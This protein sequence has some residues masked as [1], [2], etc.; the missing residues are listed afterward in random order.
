MLHFSD[1]LD[2]WG[3]NVCRL[4]YYREVTCQQ[5]SVWQ[6][7]AK[8][9]VL[10]DGLKKRW[11]DLDLDPL[12]ECYLGLPL[13]LRATVIP[14][15]AARPVL[16]MIK[17]KMIKMKMVQWLLAMVQGVLVMI[18]V[19]R[20]HLHPAQHHVM[21]SSKKQGG[22]WCLV[23]VKQVGWDNAYIT[24]KKNNATKSSGTEDT[25]LES[26]HR[27][28]CFTEAVSDWM[29][30]ENG[31]TCRKLGTLSKML[32]FFLAFFCYSAMMR[33]LRV[34]GWIEY[35]F[36]AYVRLPLVSKI[37]VYCGFCKP[38]NYWGSG[39]CG[40]WW[41]LKELTANRVQAIC[42]SEFGHGGL[43]FLLAN[44][45]SRQ[46]FGLQGLNVCM[47]LHCVVFW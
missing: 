12:I 29:G 39:A 24:S 44:C 31:C 22:Q 30:F 15:M 19:Q 3:Y 23:E 36:G 6:W 38:M 26:S 4:H 13:S 10:A 8:V 35:A 18:P 17:M 16:K 21:I 7:E 32:F 37:K 45:A 1:R 43:K 46:C 34:L 25:W 33:N 42:H 28:H 11:P 14:L 5:V 41:A 20:V 9:E 40:S 27:A 47:F 2:I